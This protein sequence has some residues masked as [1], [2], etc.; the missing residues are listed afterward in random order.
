MFRDKSATVSIIVFRI[1]PCPVRNC[2]K[3][4]QDFEAPKYTTFVEVFRTIEGPRVKNFKKM[5]C[6]LIY[7]LELYRVKIS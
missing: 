4:L 3:G 2:N 5:A 7:N 6:V 1:S